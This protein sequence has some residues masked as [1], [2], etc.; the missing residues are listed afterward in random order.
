MIGEFEGVGCDVDGGRR[1]E[2]GSDCPRGRTIVVLLSYD[3]KNIYIYIYKINKIL[4][5]P[6]VF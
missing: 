2:L 1:A 3:T 4:N 5:P 6:S